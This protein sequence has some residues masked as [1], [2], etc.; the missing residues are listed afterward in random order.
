MP[1]LKL[2]AITAL[3]LVI[4][5]GVIA[6]AGL[7]RRWV[8]HLGLTE[9]RHV[10]LRIWDWWS[11]SSNEEYGDYFGALEDEFEARNPDVDI[12]YQVVPFGN[13]VQKLSTAMVGDTPPDVFQSSVYWAEGFYHRGMLLPLNNLLDAD[14]ALPGSPAYVGESAF[15]PSAWQHNHTEATPGRPAVVY[16]IPQIIDASCLLWNLDI[17][18]AAAGEDES[19]RALFQHNAAGVID[20]D[21]IRWNGIESWDHFREITRKLTVRN[22][23]D[24]VT[25]AG[26]LLSASSGA[27]LFSPWL[28]ANG[29]RFQ[30]AA[31]TRAMFASPSGIEAV[32]FI[33]RLYWV[34]RVCPP[35]RRQM[36]D[37]EMFKER[38][39]AVVAAG[40]WSGKD[41]TRDTM[42]WTHFGKT[43]FPPG[44]SG[45]GP[46]TVTWGNM[47][48]ITQR[49]ENVDAAWRYVK[50]VGGLEGSLL[51]S[52][53]LGYN[54]PRFD[55][56]QTDRW[57][58]ALRERPY[59]SNVKQ[60]CLAGDKLRH[61][62]IIAV[63]HQANPIVES[64]L[65]RY[66]EIIEGR[67]PYPS[68]EVAMKTAAANVDNVYRRYNE[69]V[70]SWLDSRG[71]A[72]R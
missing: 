45:D 35:F 70:A 5:G 4:V 53:H 39:A 65:L 66:P 12:I 71:E 50:F 23:D 13:Y 42:G 64:V 36:T 24:E 18:Q 6:R 31:G 67:G 7:T 14:P 52:V 37:S 47:L 59:L 54:G 41:I 51:R 58:Q 15:L 22:E 49:C 68:V 28:A 40:T 34:D 11:A 60:I 43:A 72:G 1:R 3:A 10:K 17:L 32:E 69:Q 38:R 33:A 44:P 55:F 57:Q 8:S 61:T 2:L 27:G 21:R 30:D 48:V 63:D 56:Y 46:A 26:F 25:Q 62:E 16:G 29:G 20:W 9:T 19:I